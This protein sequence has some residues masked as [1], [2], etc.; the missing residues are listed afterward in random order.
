MDWVGGGCVWL[1]EECVLGHEYHLTGSPAQTTFGA[2][3]EAE[4][5]D[6]AHL[7]PHLLAPEVLQ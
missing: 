3:A 7:Q 4:G 2:G 1:S 5:V 6:R